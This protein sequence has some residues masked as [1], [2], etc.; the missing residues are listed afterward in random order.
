MKRKRRITIENLLRYTEYKVNYFK[1]CIRFPKLLAHHCYV[2]SR[3][4]LFIGSE[5][6]ISFG[7]DIYL[8]R[9]FTGNFYGRITIGDGVFFQHS[10]NLSVHE[11]VTIGD[12]ALFGERVSIH[13][14]DH[15]VTAGSDPII[16]RGFVKKP[17][18]IGRN[19]WVGANASILSGVHI[20]DNAVIGANAV[21]T[22]DIP[23]YTVAVG[24]PARV[25]REMKPSDDA[26]SLET[27]MRAGYERRPQSLIALRSGG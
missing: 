4:R 2:G 27:Q 23:A 1:W 6:E 17:I 20:G 21:V 22:H 14:E 8:M 13:D 25:I 3:S 5:A 12:Y 9:N 7:R 26:A 18:V 16:H 11:D 24:I 10:C 19:V 15:V